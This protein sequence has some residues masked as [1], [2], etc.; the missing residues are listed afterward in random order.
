MD[1]AFLEHSATPEAEIIG[2]HWGVANSALRPLRPGN[3]NIDGGGFKIIQAD[4]VKRY[5]YV[6]YESLRRGFIDDL[7]IAVNDDSTVQIRTSSRI[8][9][10][11]FQVNAKRLNYIAKL[12]ASSDV[13]G[14]EY[15]PITA[16]THPDYFEANHDK[17]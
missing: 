12:L 10:L 5:Y 16:K 6:Q 3:E 14:F 7:E 4:P 11:D 9:Y 13:K 8:G 17:R 2:E 1:F 15:N